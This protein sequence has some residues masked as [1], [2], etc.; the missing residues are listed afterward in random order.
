MIIILIIGE[1]H[2][3]WQLGLPHPSGGDCSTV[4][5]AMQDYD[6]PQF[7]LCIGNQSQNS[8]SLLHVVIFD[9]H[10]M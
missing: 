2:S 6:R 9:Q 5:G 7:L 3:H 8:V 1:W 4:V 10:T